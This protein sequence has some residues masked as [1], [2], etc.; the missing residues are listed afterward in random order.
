MKKLIIKVFIAGAVVLVA[1]CVKPKDVPDTT[2]EI[3][4]YIRD[5]ITDEPISGIELTI[6]QSPLYQT[7]AWS[8]KD[9]IIHSDSSGHFYLKKKLDEY[10][11]WAYMIGFSGNIKYDGIGGLKR[12]NV[13]KENVFNI[14]LL[15][16]PGY[17]TIKGKVLSSET[18][19]IIKFNNNVR[20]YS[21][22][23]NEYAEMAVV[24]TE[25]DTLGNYFIE[26]NFFESDTFNSYFIVRSEKN[27]K[28]NRSQNYP[29]E[30]GKE[31]IIDIQVEEVK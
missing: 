4:G 8:K 30:R 10:K 26:H 13:G 2:T 1:S 3:E 12:I 23:R 6:Y 16:F 7:Q 21:I 22:S 15:Q 31:N 28:Y 25:T 18:G 24:S 19:Q 9:T 11:D 5:S 14:K 17:T 20:L 29:V 27:E